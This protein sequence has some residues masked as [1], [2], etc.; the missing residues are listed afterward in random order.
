MRERRN[1]R[2]VDTPSIHYA[3]TADALN[4]AYEVLGDGPADL[5]VIP[6]V[7]SN[8]EM[9]WENPRWSNFMRRLSSFS[10]L[11]LFDR[12]GV[13][14]SDRPG[15]VPSLEQRMDDVR[16]VMDAVGSER[17]A[18]FGMG[19]DGA[20]ATLFGATYPERTSGLV[21]YAVPARGSWAPD[22]P[23]APK[24]DRA[25]QLIEEAELIVDDPERIRAQARRQFPSLAEDE[26]V[27]AMFARLTR[28]SVSP[29]SYA[30]LRRMNLEIDIR[31]VLPT[32]RVPTLILHRTGDRLWPVD[33]SRAT[34][35]QI[36]GAVYRE[37][38]GIDHNPWVGDQDSLL[39]IVQG[40]LEGVWTD[41]PWEQ[42]EPDRVLATVLFTD[43]VGS[44]DRA[45]ALGDAA[46]RDLLARHNALVRRELL[47]FRGR[48]VDTAGD[49]FFASFDG[50]AR[51]IQCAR[52]IEEAVGDL[53]IDV[54]IGLHVGECELVDGKIAGVA[55][56]IGARVAAE[57]GPGEILV[58]Q[59]VR[60][61]VVGS[62][63]EF[64][65]RGPRSLRGIPEPTR[66]YAVL[67]PEQRTSSI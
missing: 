3:R 66:L 59:T 60:D 49:G 4:I 34:A 62:G 45:V 26:E 29:G 18:L 10:R 30:A 56:H 54:R 22:Y 27:L 55:V 36:A 65:D 46:W 14:L 38:D 23:W 21:L 5:I 15:G 2:S 37:L 24:P 43:I 40:F 41:K 12:R 25:H 9:Y 28:L 48:E 20:M 44:T 33:V 57:A 1:V 58:S 47:R 67:S 31:H 42:A 61:L 32:I 63:I 17:A 7:A 35:Q 11:L 13:G 16:A 19:A 53:G 6:G 8:I 39:D 51:A 64:E 52:A 50:P